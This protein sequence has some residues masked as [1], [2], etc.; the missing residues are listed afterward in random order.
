MG[1]YPPSN[2]TLRILTAAVLVPLVLV[3]LYLGPPASLLFG[4]LVMVILFGEWSRLCVKN[5]LSP[6]YKRLVIVLGTLYLLIATGFLFAQLFAT[7]TGWRLLYWLLFLVWST[8]TAAFAGG[9][10]FGGPKLA[11]SIS[12]NKTWSGF[13]AGL[14][15]GSLVGYVSSLWLFPTVGLPGTI[16][17][18][19]IAQGGD[20]LESLAKRWSDV[21]DSGTL[22]FGHGGLLDRLD[23]LLAVSFV[24]A[25]SFVFSFCYPR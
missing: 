10:F 22:V 23:S 1:I 18:V 21:K 19:A 20:L 6:P 3:I 15:G 9:K 13:A 5:K 8:D 2:L 24:L 4:A 17:L 14:L 11:P 7:P 25:L 12:P 16:F